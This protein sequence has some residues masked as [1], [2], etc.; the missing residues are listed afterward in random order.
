MVPEVNSRHAGVSPVTPC[1][2]GSAG[3]SRVGSRPRTPITPGSAAA[4]SRR[5]SSASTM[6]TSPRCAIS[7][8]R[9]SGR[10]MSSSTHGVPVVSAASSAA[11]LVVSCSAQMPIDGLPGA[12][13]TAS[14][15]SA[16]SASTRW[17]SSP[18]VRVPS[19]ASS[20][21]ASGIQWASSASRPSTVSSGPGGCRSGSPSAP[22]RGAGTAPVVVL[23]VVSVTVSPC[24]STAGRLRLDSAHRPPRS[25]SALGAGYVQG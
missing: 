20:A 9:A 1:C 17:Y 19:A 8:T 11:M 5:A 18:K 24:R 15:S 6:P 14:T 7:A 4:A 16:E 25:V 10:V 22:E 23:V 12:A 21:T 13:S 2:T 3:A